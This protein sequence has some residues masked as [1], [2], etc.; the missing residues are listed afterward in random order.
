MITHPHVTFH[1]CIKPG[2]W[3]KLWQILLFGVWNE[4]AW[5][6]YTNY[7]KHSEN[8]IWIERCSNDKTNLRKSPGPLGEL[9]LV[10]ADQCK[11]KGMKQA[12]RGECQRWNT[13]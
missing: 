1:S 3:S 7:V 6:F 4:G 12:K 9:P 13:T 8:G 10:S 2:N 5:I 11:A